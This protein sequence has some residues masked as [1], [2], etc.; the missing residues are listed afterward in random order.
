[1]LWHWAKRRHPDKSKHRIARKYWYTV[2]NRNWVFSDE[3]KH[4]DP[5]EF[6]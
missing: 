2:G 5:P 6:P 3:D 4:P 1:M